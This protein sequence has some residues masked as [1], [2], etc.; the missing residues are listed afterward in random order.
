[1]RNNE[2]T[3][4]PP[5]INNGFDAVICAAGRKLGVQMLCQ[6][7]RTKS[8]LVL[9]KRSARKRERQ[10]D[11]EMLCEQLVHP[12]AP[13]KTVLNQF[14]RSLCQNHHTIGYLNGPPTCLKWYY[15]RQLLPPLLFLRRRPAVTVVVAVC[16]CVAAAVGVAARYP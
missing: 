5:A 1:M 4:N 10:R 14:S 6:T 12:S 13:S 11:R 16:L 2:R 7:P 8:S 15:Q 3:R 9:M